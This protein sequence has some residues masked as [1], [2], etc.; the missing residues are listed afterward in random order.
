MIWLLYDLAALLIVIIAAC[1]AAKRGFMRTLVSFVGGLAALVG[2]YF[3]SEPAARWVFAHFVRQ[4][5][6]DSVLQNLQGFTGTDA[7]AALQQGMGKWAGWLAHLSGEE[8][9]IAAHQL[10]QSLSKGVEGMAAA[11]PRR[12]AGVRVTVMAQVLSRSSSA[13]PAGPWG[14]GCSRRRPP[15][16]PAGWFRRRSSCRSSR[17]RRVHRR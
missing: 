16:P 7:G 8:G 2:A 15:A 12:G 9:Q 10:E 1:T 11:V 5:V 14:A 6:Y 3:A 13:A 4:P 17:R